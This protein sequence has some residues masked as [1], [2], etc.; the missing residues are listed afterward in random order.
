MR[1]SHRGPKMT[2]ARA[3]TTMISGSGKKR[4]I[5]LALQPQP[6]AVRQF[7]CSFSEPIHRTKEPEDEKDRREDK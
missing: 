3:A 7:A 4:I 1:Q 5:R 2:A 6:G